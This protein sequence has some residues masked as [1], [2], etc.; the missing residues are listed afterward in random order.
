[1]M[2]F[3]N[4]LFSLGVL[5]SFFSFLLFCLQRKHLLNALLSLEMVMLSIFLVFISLL[6]GSN[7]EG[8]MTFILLVFM[9][10]EASLGLS[11]LVI[12]IRSHGNDYVSSM[13]MHK[14]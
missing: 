6:T 1:M 12:F 8:L 13:T 2:S 9:A 10:C 7:N 14:C 11:L 4:S 5:S 3:S